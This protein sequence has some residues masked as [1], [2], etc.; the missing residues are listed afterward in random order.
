MIAGQVQAVSG[1]VGE[2][3]QD[4]AAGKVRYLATTGVKH[5]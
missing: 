1:P 3:T 5:L 2:F 4:V